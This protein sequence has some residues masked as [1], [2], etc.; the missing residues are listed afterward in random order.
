M[1]P[2]E[3]VR[4]AASP[5]PGCSTRVDVEA[6]IE[7]NPRHDRL[8]HEILDKATVDDGVRSSSPGDRASRIARS[9]SASDAPETAAISM[10]VLRGPSSGGNGHELLSR[11]GRARDDVFGAVLERARKVVFEHA[12]HRRLSQ[13]QRVPSGQGGSGIQQVGA[14]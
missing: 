9:T 11:H 10:S 2:L 1:A 8:A 3:H 7:R 6:F 12:T 14:H 13:L 4:R 5:E